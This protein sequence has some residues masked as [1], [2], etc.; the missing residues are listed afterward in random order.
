MSRKSSTQHVL[1][2]LYLQSHTRQWVVGDAKNTQVFVWIRC[3]LNRWLLFLMWRKHLKLFFGSER[4]LADW[5]IVHTV[6]FSVFFRNC[7]YIYIYKLYLFVYIYIYLLITFYTHTDYTYLHWNLPLP[8]PLLTNQWQHIR[9]IL[10]EGIL[11]AF[12]VD[13]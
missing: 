8:L 4:S 13:C 11:H 2:D 6:C 5:F 1:T 12:I 3:V 7:K 9:F 10:V